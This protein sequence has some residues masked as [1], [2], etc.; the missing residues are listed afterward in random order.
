MFWLNG[1]FGDSFFKKNVNGT[2]GSSAASEDYTNSTSQTNKSVSSNTNKCFEKN[3]SESDS[4]DTFVN[5]NDGARCSV[6]TLWSD[7]DFGSNIFNGI[8]NG[9]FGWHNSATTYATYEE[10]GSICDKP[11]WGDDSNSATT[12]VKEEGGSSSSDDSTNVTKTLGE[13]GG[14][15]DPNDGIMTL[16]MLED[17]GSSL[18]GQISTKAMY[19]E[20]GSDSDKPSLGDKPF[21]G[22][23]HWGH[24]HWGSGAVTLAMLEDGGSS[25]DG[26]ISTK[27]MYEEG[28]S[29]SDK[30]SLGD[31]PFWG[32]HHWGHHHWGSGAVTLA[33]LEDG[34]S[35]LDGQIST[36]AMYEEGG[37]DSDK[38]SWGDKPD[39]DKPSWGDK[40]DCDKPSWGDKP[41][42]GHHHWGHHH[43]GGGAVTLAMLECG[44]SA[45]DDGNITATRCED[46]GQD[47]TPPS[48]GDD[49]VDVPSVDDDNN[50]EDTPSVDDDNNN[51]GGCDEQ[52]EVDKPQDDF[53]ELTLPDDNDFGSINA[54][55]FIAYED[56][57]Q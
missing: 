40:P 30:P 27:A 51:D 44:G 42:W 4:Y 2:T 8:F 19:E 35:S 48:C 33:M 12:A 38:P 6:S 21:W 5:Y 10:G 46:G 57:G 15:S 54:T 25:L 39:C 3:T 55:T 9:I 34:G 24:H 23:H 49:N 22:H 45:G 37:S 41:F 31:K 32:H 18:D 56:G 14:D 43:W 11:S 52:P 28:G 50:N 47:V 29:D 53:P 13:S 7:C 20:G 17:G 1:C 16:A 36:K 26:Q